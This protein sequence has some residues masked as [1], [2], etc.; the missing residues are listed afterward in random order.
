MIPFRQYLIEIT[1][2]A[3]TSSWVLSRK[4]G[5]EVMPKTR[6]DHPVLF[7]HIFFPGWAYDASGWNHPEGKAPAQ[8]W[9]RIDND[10]KDIHIVSPL[11]PGRDGSLYGAGVHS[12][13][14]KRDIEA[15]MEA[16]EHLRRMYPDY[17]LDSGMLDDSNAKIYHTFDQH[18]KWLSG[19]YESLNN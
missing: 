9:G 4:H 17:R 1:S 8:V 16:V 18:I 13:H 2:W 7:P 5:F 19:K 15:R 6:D 10:N 11:L 14:V 3:N 12:S